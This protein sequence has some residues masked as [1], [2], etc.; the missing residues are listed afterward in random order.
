MASV[1]LSMASV[2]LPERKI[3]QDTISQRKRKKLKKG[4]LI[5]SQE[6]KL[7]SEIASIAFDFN[8]CAAS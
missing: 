5:N 3:N 2:K 7:P 4:D 8:S 1:R 6:K